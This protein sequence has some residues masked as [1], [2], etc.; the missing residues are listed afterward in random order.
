MSV[1]Q[2]VSLVLPHIVKRGMFRAFLSQKHVIPSRQY[3]QQRRNFQ[4]T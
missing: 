3:M 4:Y 1:M 2:N